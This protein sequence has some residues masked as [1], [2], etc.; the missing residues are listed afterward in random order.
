MAIRISHQSCKSKFVYEYFGSE[1]WPGGRSPQ[2][3]AYFTVDQFKGQVP[4]RRKGISLQ[5][6]E[7]M[8]DNPYQAASPGR[9]RKRP[10]LRCA[11]RRQGRCKPIAA[12]FARGWLGG[13]A[14]FAFELRG[15]VEAP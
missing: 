12:T 10:C 2:A 15:V 3:G 14:G 6:D 5:G 11:G 7:S 9:T 1:R 8:F 4:V 13:I